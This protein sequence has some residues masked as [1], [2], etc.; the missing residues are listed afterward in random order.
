MIIGPFYVILSN[1]FY[2]RKH[3]IFEYSSLNTPLV[4]STSFIHYALAKY[5]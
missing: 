5:Q 3:V 4:L 1:T 2:Q